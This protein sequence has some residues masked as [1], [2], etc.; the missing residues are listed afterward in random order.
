MSRSS[1]ASEQT[2][3]AFAVDGQFVIVSKDEDFHQAVLLTCPPPKVVWV[4][5]GNC[6]TRQVEEALR[7]RRTQIERFIA[8]VSAAFLTLG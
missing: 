3:K 8:D 7:D 4:R 1:A 6:T 2:I 5:L